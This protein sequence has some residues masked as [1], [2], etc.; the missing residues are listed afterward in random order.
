MET[1]SEP[2][3]RRDLADPGT[4]GLVATP[5]V[6]KYAPGS[7]PRPV[8][9]AGQLLTYRRSHGEKIGLTGTSPKR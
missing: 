6:Q 1:P 5:H 4:P 3:R 9:Q 2:Y 7:L 8:Y